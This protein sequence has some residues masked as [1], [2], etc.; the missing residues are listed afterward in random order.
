[1][2]SFKMMFV[3]ESSV[4]QSD[5]DQNGPPTTDYSKENKNDSDNLHRGK[6]E[7]WRKF[8]YC[9]IVDGHKSLSANSETLA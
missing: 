7:F 9:S 8:W 6:K 1:M 3:Q 5:H 2:N 4:G